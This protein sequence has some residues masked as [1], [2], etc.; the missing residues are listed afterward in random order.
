[1]GFPA[2]GIRG[3]GTVKVWGR[4]LF[5][6]PAIGTIIFMKSVKKYGL[7]GNKI[8]A[9]FAR[10]CFSFFIFQARICISGFGTGPGR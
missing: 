5:P 9:I 3:F 4:I 1:M 10:T 6:R 7:Q 2:M 8:K